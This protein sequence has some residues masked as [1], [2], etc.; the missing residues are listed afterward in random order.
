V[1]DNPEKINPARSAFNEAN[2]LIQYIKKSFL[3]DGSGIM[4]MMD[5]L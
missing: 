1:F 4:Q 5:S 2:R 3:I